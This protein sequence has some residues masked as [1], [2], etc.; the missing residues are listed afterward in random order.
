MLPAKIKRL[1]ER[2][3]NK[4]LCRIHTPRMIWG[5]QD[6]SGEWRKQT[7]ISSTVFF[8]HPERIQIHE[9]VF[10][11][12]HTILDGTGYLEIGEGTQIGAWVGIFTHSS[13]IAIRLYGKHYQ[14]V[15]E[16]K[17]IAYPK[18]KTVIGK[19][20]FIGASA[21]ILPGVKISDGALISAGSIVSKD[22]KKFAIVS[23]NPATVVGST[24]IL[25]KRYLKDSKIRCWYEEWQNNV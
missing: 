23:G 4:I 12:H 9:N 15:H 21:K 13:H 17:K 5:Y 22:V 3:F 14:E 2:T 1:L 24:K 8:Y 11:W 19:Y 16:D 20:V 6:S 7:R 25:D 10:I 18:K